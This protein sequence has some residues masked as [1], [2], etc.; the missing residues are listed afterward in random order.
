MRLG[1]DPGE[2]YDIRSYMP[3]DNIRQ[4]HWKLTGKLDDV[5][6][7]EKSYPVDDTVLLLAESFQKDRNPLRAEA[8]AEVFAAAF[9]CIDIN[10][11]PTSLPRSVLSLNDG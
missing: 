4:I 1:D 6:I 8:A 9:I 7:R 11:S 3:G 10:A 5:M 2:T